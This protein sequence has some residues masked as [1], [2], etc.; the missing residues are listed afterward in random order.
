MLSDN[1]LKSA[2]LNFA[3]RLYKKIRPWLYDLGVLGIARRLLS[4]ER[5]QRIAVRLGLG[6]FDRAS[7]TGRRVP[8]WA[9]STQRKPTYFDGVNIIGDMQTTTGISEVTRQIYRALRSVNTPVSYTEAIF[10]PHERSTPL[11][12]DIKQGNIYQFNLIDVHFS[13]FY[14]IVMEMDAALFTDKYNIAMWGWE[15]PKFPDVS[16]NIFSLTDEIW[17]YS[18]FVQDSIAHVSPV[19]VIRIPPAVH[20]HHNPKAQRADFDLPQDRTIFLFT[21]SPASMMARKNP[22][23]V[24]EAFKRAFGAAN[25]KAFL[26]LKTHHMELVSGRSQ[27]EEDLEIAVASVNGMLIVDHLSRQQFFDLITVSDCY[28]SLHRS[29]GFGLGMAEAM[30]MGKPVIATAYSG[31]V[32]YMNIWNSYLVGYKLRPIMADD[33]YYQPEFASTFEVGQLWAEPNIDEA[34]AHMQ[35][36]V[37]NPI[38]AQQR[39]QRAR[40]NIEALLSHQAVGKRMVERLNA[41]AGQ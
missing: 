18:S 9:Q 36:I 4:E 2:K 23:G 16:R 30:A 24:V 29:E 8:S 32:D 17:V 12:E 28:I 14:D 22:F 26:V 31:N 34:A 20:V 35:H 37:D 38:A 7:A 11:P 15:L 1:S 6:G 10:S 3:K 5:R 19:P 41:I 40:Q 27:L 25:D 21:F 33:H 39:G 13:Q